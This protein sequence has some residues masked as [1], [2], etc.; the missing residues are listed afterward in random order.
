[1][2]L[3]TKCGTEKDESE[4]SRD[5]T[6]PGRRSHCKQCRSEYGRLYRAG[7][8]DKIAEYDHVYRIENKDNVA[9]TKRLYCIEN[10]DKIA[11]YAHVYSIE[12]KDLISM[13][14]R[15]YG[16]ENRSV[17][18]EYDKVKRARNPEQY[19]KYGKGYCQRYP[20]RCRESNMISILKSRH[21]MKPTT[22]TDPILMGKASD[23]KQLGMRVH[24]IAEKLS[25]E[26]GKTITQISLHRLFQSQ[27]EEPIPELLESDYPS[28]QD[29]S[30]IFNIKFK[31]EKTATVIRYHNT[32]M[33]RDLLQRILTKFYKN[34][35]TYYDVKYECN[36]RD[37]D[38]AFFNHWEYLL[39]FHYIEHITDTEFGFCDIVKRWH[40]KLL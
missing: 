7:N 40:M 33:R 25:V 29:I 6:H 38:T 23:M 13:Q 36:D 14:K 3:C 19:A 28:L 1:M 16:L 9:E 8:K 2:K 31:K 12:N 17:L 30:Y 18:N 37:T 32:T 26:S 11:E 21:P 10:K 35:F 20:E 24:D 27:K 5:K 4:F 22:I 15:E 39:H 34:N